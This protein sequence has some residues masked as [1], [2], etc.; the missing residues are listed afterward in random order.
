MPDPGSNYC[1]GFGECTIGPWLMVF[2]TLPDG[3][4]EGALVSTQDSLWNA[5][6]EREAA[7]FHL[8]AEDGAY[9]LSGQE[10][11][12]LATYTYKTSSKLEVA[13]SIRS[14]I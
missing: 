12:T 10:K 8:H 7:A 14:S 13:S 2:R 9:R 11:A 3:D 1:S 6:H 5:D 4:L